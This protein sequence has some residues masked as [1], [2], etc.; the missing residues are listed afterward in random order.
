MSKVSVLC[1]QC[2]KWKA[3]EAGAVNR[4][5]KIGAKLYCGRKCSMLA[6]RVDNPV[7]PRNPNWK[8]IKRE[9]DRK[10]RERKGDERKSQK[11]AYYA[12]IGPTIREKERE[13]R[14][15]RMPLHLEYC[16]RPEYKAKKHAYDIQRNREEYGEYAECYDMLRILTQEINIKQPDRMQRYRESGRKQWSIATMIE[17]KRRRAKSN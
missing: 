9:Y 12:R 11:K 15:K 7:T 8:E 10:Y 14:K 4:A 2:E 17:R 3:R 16:R 5:R 13:T 6:K 1:P